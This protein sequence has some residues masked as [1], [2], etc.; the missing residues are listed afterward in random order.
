M[1]LN[2]TI[3]PQAARAPKTG[4][5][6]VLRDWIAYIRDPDNNN[7]QDFVA[8]AVLALVLA[9]CLIWIH[10]LWLG[11]LDRK[12]KRGQG[13]RTLPK[14]VRSVGTPTILVTALAAGAG[15]L[16][17]PPLL[18]TWI[19][20]LFQVTLLL[21]LAWTGRRIV[22]YSV[23]AY[24]ER[25]GIAESPSSMTTLNALSYVIRVFIWSVVLLAMLK[26]LFNLSL[27]SVVTALG[28]TGIAIA[29][30]IQNILSDLFAALS[31]IT[32]KPF[33]IGDSIQV[34][35]FSGTVEHI[36]LKT[37]RV[38]SVSGEQIIFSNSELLKSRI[39]N[40]QR[41]QHRRVVLTT[42]IA[43]DTDPQKA[44]RMPVIL[45]EIVTSRSDT[46]FDRSHLIEISDSAIVYETVYY[47]DQT[48]HLTHMNTQ[49]AIYLDLLSRCHAEEIELLA[50][51][52]TA[53]MRAEALTM[54]AAAARSQS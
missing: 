41:M 40:F 38:R 8:A 26:I 32:D 6:A 5:I 44:A 52:Q 19:A 22:T 7:P 31:I 49:Q 30:A 35:A 12:A 18:R 9:L 28:V 42:R 3:P 48:D 39:R 27:A 14:L 1:N 11:H 50:H 34:D 33:V 47:L 43:A 4:V 24:A 36:G 21:Q 25:K 16:D 46:R 37:T 17:L 13:S 45:K 10:R 23:H 53:R 51:I 2:L 29:F 20:D 54:S 15:L